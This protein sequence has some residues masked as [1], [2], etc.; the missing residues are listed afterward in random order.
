M[1]GAVPEDGNVALL[2]DA[3][4]ASYKKLDAVLAVLA[5]LGTVNIRRVYGN[6]K[7]DQ[8]QGWAE[9]TLSHG[10]EPF[11]QF[12]I[13]KG[14]S[15]T[16]MKMTIDAM[17]LLFRDR[18]T[19]FGIMSSD[20]DF[21]PLA[22]RIRQQGIPV[23]GFGEA[24]KTPIAFQAA[25]T[26]FLDVDALNTAKQAAAP[27]AAVDAGG[28]DPAI[29]A[30][31][32]ESYEQTKHDEDGFAHLGA[33]GS[34]TNNT[35]SFDLRSHGFKRLSDMIKQIPGFQMQSRD[36]VTYVKYGE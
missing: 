8:L 13:T 33:V 14:K 22:M 35:S 6:W 23:Y 34:R 29:V 21:M 32:I 15:A 25:C 7:K 2:I 24:K 9:K 30:L 20:S 36:G 5:E 28:I 12:D 10:I 1:A 4:N 26:R 31:L 19:G 11:Q 16:D 27:V 3:D 18:V 17:D